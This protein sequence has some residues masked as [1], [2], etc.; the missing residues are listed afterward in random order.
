MLLT[1]I[2]PER[3][4]VL[5]VERDLLTFAKV[6]H[7]SAFKRSRVDEHVLAAVI[8]RNEAK[9]FLIVVEFYGA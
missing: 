3:P 9:A 2:L 8:R 7:P 1:A 4:S 6:P 5:G